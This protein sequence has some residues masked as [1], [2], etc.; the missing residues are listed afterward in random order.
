MMLNSGTSQSVFL[1]MPIRRILPC[2]ID[3]RLMIVVH[4]LA[5]MCFAAGKVQADLSVHVVAGDGAPPMRNAIQRTGIGMAVDRYQARPP[6]PKIFVGDLISRINT[7]DLTKH[8][9]VC[10]RGRLDVHMVATG[11]TVSRPNA[12]RLH[13]IDLEG[14]PTLDQ[15][16][17]AA[18]IPVDLFRRIDGHRLFS[19][20]DSNAF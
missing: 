14:R 4:L 16:L 12:L 7:V 8:F 17:D 5:A 20:R 11:L 2:K 1:F 9:R 6:S 15:R 18:C 3:G 10:S 13:I 19:I